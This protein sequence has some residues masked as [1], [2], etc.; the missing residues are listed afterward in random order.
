M[1]RT[2]FPA[3][4]VM[5]SPGLRP[6]ARR[7]RLRPDFADV[8][9]LGS[10]GNL[11]RLLRVLGQILLGVG[12]QDAERRALRSGEFLRQLGELRLVEPEN[13]IAIGDGD[14][15]ALLAADANHLHRRLVIL[16]DVLLDEG[17]LVSAKELLSS[18]APWSGVGRVNGDLGSSFRHRISSS[19]RSGRFAMIGFSRR[20]PNRMT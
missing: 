11:L 19:L 8:D 7:D 18:I 20:R 16:G 13:D 10:G 2:R 6:A 5:T 15:H 4:L 3:K 12:G 17:N 14:G 9:A 1:L